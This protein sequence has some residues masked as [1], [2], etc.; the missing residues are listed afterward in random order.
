MLDEALKNRPRV[1]NPY[2]DPQMQRRMALRRVPE[3]PIDMLAV[4]GDGYSAG[5]ARNAMKT[6]YD[7]WTL[8]REA[9]RNP[10][11]DLRE[12]TR[13]GDAALM[14]GTRSADQASERIV[15]QIAE[16]DAKIKAAIEPPI[17]PQLA[18][19][20]R[21]LV[22]EDP[23]RATVLAREDARFAGAILSGPAALSGL[24]A[25]KISAVRNAAMLAH[26]PD[27]TTQKSEAERAL[28][29]LHKAG[30]RTAAE[31]GNKLASWSAGVPEELGKLKE[32]ARG[33]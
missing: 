13:L 32:A 26:A 4:K 28:A 15:R 12:L 31:I 33:T 29:A 16:F 30:S 18:T 6:L 11:T 25:D 21:A 23:A 19:E 27:Q 22:R 7:T 10:E 20:L 3:P 8:V 17:T 1:R 14:K 5:L 9:A 2:P 24:D